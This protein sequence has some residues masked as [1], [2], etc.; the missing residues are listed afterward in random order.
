[1]RKVALA[2]VVAVSL[3]G[4]ASIQKITSALQQTSTYVSKEN[5]Y[6]AENAAIVMF[7]GLNTYRRSCVQ[8]LI[9]QSCRQTIGRIQVYTRRIPPALA[10][11]RVFVRA[12]SPN[13]IGAYNLVITL[14]DAAKGEARGAI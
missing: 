14:I 10:E 13:A 2:L 7:A 5:L 4:C 6:Y 11:L 3:G 12:G 8:N 9:P 1:M